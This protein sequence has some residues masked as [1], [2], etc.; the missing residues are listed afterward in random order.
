M[1][2]LRSDTVTKPC[3]G[4]RR[5][6]YE[7]EVGDDVYGEDIT[8]NKLQ[9]KCAEMF[10]K[11]AGLYVPS[12]T[13]SNQIAIKAHTQPGEELIC[14]N[15]AHIYFYET[16]G[17]AFLS[18]VQVRPVASEFGM[19][20]I[21]DVDKTIRPDV[22]YFP[23]TSL[24]CVENTHNRHGG[25]VLP[26]KEVVELGKFVKSKNLIYHCDG[27]R[28]W[29]AAVKN[30]LSLKEMAEPFDTIS[31]CLSK[32]M[33]APVG[34][35]LLGDKEFIKK[36]LKIRKIFGGGMRQAGIIAAAA[37]YA[38]ENNYE[39][40]KLDHENA[41]EFAKIL[42]EYQ[43]ISVDMQRVQTNMVM[44]DLANRINVNE[45]IYNAKEAGVLISGLEGQRIRAVFHLQISRE[46][47][48][49]AANTI[50]N[51]SNDLLR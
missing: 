37:L 6:M 17:P 9:D 1:I 38:I 2:D 34:S 35:V 19:M 7:A 31:V 33:G 30:E 46:M 42:N 36:S 44:F 13:M 4:M 50:I 22:Y 15:D 3:E 24:V 32:G 40:I 20:K 39:K 25:S 45:F 12:G 29:N 5:A 49:E 11:E 8:I 28:I 10:G 26:Q 23:K 14:E 41:Q 16:A 27:A 43:F 48:V 18:N 21:N 47:A 51:I